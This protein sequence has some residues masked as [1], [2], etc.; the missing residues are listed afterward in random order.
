[1]GESLTTSIGG[2][3]A[4]W[5]P[6]DGP[7]RA[8]LTFRVGW[9]DETL[10]Q[11][12][13]T[14]LVEHLVLAPLGQPSFD[15]NGRTTADTTTF[16]CSGRPEE[17][18]WF[19]GAVAESISRPGLDGL[20]VERRLLRTE[21]QQ[22][23][24]NLAA[25]HDLW[26]WGARGHGQAGFDEYGLTSVDGG[27][28]RAW[29]ARYFTVNNAILWVAGGSLDGVE[30]ALPEGVARPASTPG[31]RA[32]ATPRSFNADVSTV[33][34]SG[35]VA[36]G[37]WAGL[38][39]WLLQRRLMAR[40]RYDEGVTYG[41]QTDV[42]DCG[43]D[44]RRVLVNIDA[45]PGQLAQ[46]AT[47]AAEVLAELA[48]QG[49]TADE[50]GTWHVGLTGTLNQPDAVVLDLARRAHDALL[51]RPERSMDE[52]LAE[53]AQLTPEGLRAAFSDMADS[54]LWCVPAGVVVPGVVPASEG[55]AERVS[56]SR[57][58]PPIGQLQT[59]YLEVAHEGITWVADDTRHL[60]IT[61]RWTDCVAVLA[62][63]DGSRVIIG[64]D[65]Y[66]I[67]L[68]PE[69]WARYDQL[70]AALSRLVPPAAWSVQGRADPRP[71]P[72]PPVMTREP[73]S[74]SVLLILAGSLWLTA[75]LLV[76]V[77]L[78]E[79][80]P[81]TLVF[82][83]LVAIVG[84]LP[85][86]HVRRRIVRRRQG[87]EPP[88]RTRRYVG[89]A[90]WSSQALAGGLGASALAVLAGVAAGSGGLVLLGTAAAA[91]CLREVFRR[92]Q[93]GESSRSRPRTRQ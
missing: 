39:A 8:A 13:L 75:L 16:Y 48:A 50:L 44:T 23:G 28:V 5:A 32:T 43:P 59:Q 54:L 47:G 31:S 92:H 6:V 60:V 46:A 91:P 51:G 70:T 88:T 17:V 15:W 25:L 24:G 71:E 2:V 65:G 41:V 14:H 62:Y 89:T 67:A 4:L 7:V 69:R 29:L 1:M 79:H 53:A 81:G 38:V 26:R 61:I 11:H 83:L 30:L 64:A 10:P 36:V 45:L 3:R 87:L 34:L 20:E 49:P 21:A 73:I 37:R 33:S 63:D 93:R 55:S 72:A 18:A 9:A 40:L 42:T 77:R 76:G 90:V 19:I 86:R 66:R 80:D 85:A 58:R 22:R 35:E 74:S 12:G 56:G 57:Y 78:G 82:A 68:Y 84:A 52:I 27:D